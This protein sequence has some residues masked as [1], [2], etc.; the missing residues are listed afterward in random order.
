[1]YQLLSEY[2]RP[3]KRWHSYKANA[4]INCLEIVFWG[5]VAFLVMQANLKRCSGV[6]CYLSWGVVGIAIVLKYVVTDRLR[7]DFY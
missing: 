2:S 5:A 1:M 7:S 6:T 3:F 4:I